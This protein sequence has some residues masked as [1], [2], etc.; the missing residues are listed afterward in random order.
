MKDISKDHPAHYRVLITSG[1]PPKGEN[2]KE[3]MYMMTSRMQTMHAESDANLSRFLQ[4]FNRA[5]AYLLHPAILK[6][7]SPEFLTELAILKRKLSVKVPSE[8][9]QHDPEVMALGDELY[10]EKFGD[11][12]RKP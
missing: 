3:K 2:G 12:S 7:G 1:F 8:V 10:R 9:N 5:R 4:A 11:L 6:N